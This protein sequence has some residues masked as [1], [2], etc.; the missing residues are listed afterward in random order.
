MTQITL[1]AEI[2]LTVIQFHSFRAVET[3]F[4]R[5]FIPP[6]SDIANFSM[7]YIILSKVYTDED[8]IK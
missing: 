4:K 3:V 8:G 6:L 7:I 5:S 1:G 2:L